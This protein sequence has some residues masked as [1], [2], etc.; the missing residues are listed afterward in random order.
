MAPLSLEELKEVKRFSTLPRNLTGETNGPLTWR[1]GLQIP[2]S[3]FVQRTGVPQTLSGQVW[4]G[5]VYKCADWTSKPCWL[6][7]KKNDGFHNPEGFGAFI[8]E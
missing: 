3:L 6:M 2:L 4:Y 8:F 5:N 7:W 1:L